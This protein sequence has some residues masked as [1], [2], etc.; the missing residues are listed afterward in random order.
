LVFGPGR[1]YVNNANNIIA[2]KNVYAP[3]TGYEGTGT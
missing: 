1:S 2:F 3:I